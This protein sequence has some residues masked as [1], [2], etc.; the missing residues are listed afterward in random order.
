MKI[1]IAQ[2]GKGDIGRWVWYKPTVGPM[3]KGRV[4]SWNSEFVFI[5]YK[6]NGEWD[7][8]KDFTGAATGPEDFEFIK[9]QDHCQAEKGFV[10]ACLAPDVEISEDQLI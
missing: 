10:C 5:V 2:L 7:R 6:C 8:F 1:D 4:K 9:H 3:E